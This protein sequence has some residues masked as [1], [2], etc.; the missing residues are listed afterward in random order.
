MPTTIPLPPITTNTINYYNWNISDIV[1]SSMGTLIPSIEIPPVVVTD[2]PNPLNKTGV[3]HLPYVT[4]TISI[5][6]WPWTTDDTSKYP[7]VTFTEAFATDLVYLTAA[8][9]ALLALL[10]R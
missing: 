1:T 3:T 5:P 7:T 9:R 2:N 6:P 4:R 10:I 8:W